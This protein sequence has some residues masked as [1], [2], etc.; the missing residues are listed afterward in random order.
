MAGGESAATDKESLDSIAG[1]RSSGLPGLLAL[2]GQ[3]PKVSSMYL[4]L[5]LWFCGLCDSVGDIAR[6][7]SS[8]LQNCF[9][10]FESN[11]SMLYICQSL[12]VFDFDNHYCIHHLIP[13]SCTKKIISRMT[14]RRQCTRPPNA[15]G[16]GQLKVGAKHDGTE[17]RG[18]EKPSANRQ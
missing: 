16:Q 13:A 10:Y 4:N 17:T 14:R 3:N 7:F 5:P 1:S 12:I 2:S 6:L 9:C 8:Y 18:T 15:H 11:L